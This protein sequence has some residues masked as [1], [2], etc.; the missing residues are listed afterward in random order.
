MIPLALV[1]LIV[2]DMMPIAPV[3]SIVA[4]AGLI[5]L[6]C[7]SNNSGELGPF[8]PRAVVGMV[9]PANSP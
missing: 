8:H 5:L 3:Q 2:F 7:I 1:L 9:Y 6:R 4:I